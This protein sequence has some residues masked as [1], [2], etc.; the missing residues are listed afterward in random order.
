[1]GWSSM[2]SVALGLVLAYLVF[3][4]AA[5]QINEFVAGK[6]QWRAQGLERGLYALFGGP[7]AAANTAG[8]AVDGA[9]ADLAGQP[10]LRALSALAIKEHPIIAALDAG[11]AKDRRV[12]YLPSRAL[13]AA[14]L[15]LLAPPVALLVNDIP[16]AGLSPQAAAAL[17]QFRLTPTAAALESYAAA[18]PA[19]DPRL[20]GQMPALRA[21]LEK[22]PLE[23]IRAAVL[24]LPVDHPARRTLLRMV[25]DAKGD[26]DRFRQRVEHWF[27][28]EMDRL[29]GWYKK[30]VQ[31]WILGYGA[32]LAV[33][34]NVDTINI[35]QSL[36]ISPVAQAAATQEAINAAGKSPSEVDTSTSALDGLA[37][38][39]GW[40]APH[41]GGHVSADPRRAPDTAQQYLL[42]ILGLIIT[43]L[44]LGFGAP[45]WFDVLGRIARMRNAGNVPPK[46]DKAQG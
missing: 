33:L 24:E 7:A 22:D 43:T 9:P 1:M 18:L 31:I 29:A 4:V 15:D 32:A 14:V 44:A 36:W 40:T 35:A 3:S 27:D 6:L 37:L 16:T 5:S 46:A 28:D 13:S 19:D 8:S 12:S 21:A 26:R 17:Q 30:R 34:F 42:K 41:Q 39:I 45:F 10:Q 2:V 38:P 23:R 25:T 20:A 11:L